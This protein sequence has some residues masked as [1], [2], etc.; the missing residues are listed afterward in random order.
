M[1]TVLRYVLLAAAP[2][3]AF[4]LAQK[5]VEAVTTYDSR[6]PLA[7]LP[8]RDALTGRNERLQADYDDL[9]GRQPAAKARKLEAAAL[10]LA[11]AKD[12]L[13]R[14]DVAASLRR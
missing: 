5:A 4:L 14:H 8:S 9:K 7:Q 1:P 3:A 10:A 6:G 11:D 12:D 13:F 2:S